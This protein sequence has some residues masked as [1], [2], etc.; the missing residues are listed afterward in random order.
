MISTGSGFV[1]FFVKNVFGFH[2]GLKI[3]LAFKLFLL[4]DNAG[5]WLNTTSKVLVCRPGRSSASSVL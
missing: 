1:A 2:T 3:N 5:P 4:Y